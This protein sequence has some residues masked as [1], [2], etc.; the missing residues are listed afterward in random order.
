MIKKIN[1]HQSREHATRV[2]EEPD[3]NIAILNIKILELMFIL[4]D[5]LFLAFL[6]Q[7]GGFPQL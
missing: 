5:Y 3:Q 2:C 1:D 7:F 6:N 4:Q